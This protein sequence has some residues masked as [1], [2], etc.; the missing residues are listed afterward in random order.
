[1]PS[2]FLGG[3]LRGLAEFRITPGSVGPGHSE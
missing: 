3:I 1:M 2:R